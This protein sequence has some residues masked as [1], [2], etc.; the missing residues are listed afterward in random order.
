MDCLKLL[1]V[2]GKNFDE[3]DDS[4]I[5][6]LHFA[7]TEHQTEIAKFLIK[8]GNADL[9]AKDPVRESVLFIYVQHV[10]GKCWHIL[11]CDSI[12]FHA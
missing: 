8:N 4:G 12:L 2:Y 10:F 9:N 3:K 5:C 1:F 11:L 7:I 6:P